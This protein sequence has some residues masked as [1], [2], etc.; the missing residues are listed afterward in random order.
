MITVII[1]SHSVPYSVI[2]VFNT[3][4]VLQNNIPLCMRKV[5]GCAVHLSKSVVFHCMKEKEIPPPTTLTFHMCL[6]FCPCHVF[7][8]IYRVSQEEGTKLQESVPYVKIYRCNPKHLYPKLNGY[9]DN[10]QR[11]VW[12]SGGSTH[13]TLSAD[14]ISH[15]SL[16]A[17]SDYRNT[18]DALMSVLHYGW[19][20]TSCI[21]LGTLKDNY[22]V[23]AGF[24]V[25]QFNG[26]MSLTS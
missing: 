10:G 7:P 3:H 14:S 2:F 26:F 8:Y 24:F 17:V 18:A 21:V 23:S 25:V 4:T 15:V 6:L 22:D 19:L 12:S 13:S 9:G 1:L 16:A 20:C 5:I 11:K